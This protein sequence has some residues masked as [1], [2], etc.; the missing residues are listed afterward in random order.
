MAKP[1]EMPFELW[2]RVSPR[3]YVLDGAQVPHAKGQLLGKRHGRACPTTLYRELC[4]NG[5][6]DICRLGCGLECSEGSTSS[7]V[8]AGSMC[9]HQRAHW[10]QPANTIEPSV[11]VG[12]AALCQITLTTCYYS[13]GVLRAAYW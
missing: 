3:K 13:Y 1:I 9:P 12:A 2:T 8:F 10:C 6:T 7:V 4:K 11:C 5:W